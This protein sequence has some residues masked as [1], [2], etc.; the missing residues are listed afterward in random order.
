[1]FSQTTQG[2]VQQSLFVQAPVMKHGVQQM[3]SQKAFTTAQS[4]MNVS[5]FAAP[6]GTKYAQF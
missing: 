4:G 5:A 1:M 6:T 3:T 2:N